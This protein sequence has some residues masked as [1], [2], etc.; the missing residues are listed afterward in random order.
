VKRRLVTLIWVSIG[1][2]GEALLFVRHQCSEIESF[3]MED[4]RI[5]VFVKDTLQKTSKKFWK[6]DARPPMV[7]AVR[8][9]STQEFSPENRGKEPRLTE[10][11]RFLGRNLLPP[12]FEIT[13][14]P[15]AIGSFKNWLPKLQELPTFRR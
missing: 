1:V 9:V 2:G 14:S 11:I 6:T 7:E 10:A 8:A 12:A 15:E 4:F 5:V 13:I 3:L